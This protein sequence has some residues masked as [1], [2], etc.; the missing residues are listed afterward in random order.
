LI[1]YHNAAKGNGPRF[2]IASFQAFVLWIAGAAYSGIHSP[3][4][5]SDTTAKGNA[6]AF[7]LQ[8]FRPLFYGLQGLHIQVSTALKGHQIPAKGNGPS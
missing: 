8:A 7:I 2:H 5:A 6:P 1:L 4:R 3:E